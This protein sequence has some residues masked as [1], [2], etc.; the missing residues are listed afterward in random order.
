[1]ET[2]FLVCAILGGT[3]L[4]CQTIAGLVGHGVEH[5]TDADHDHGGDHGNGFL[6]MLTVR[7]VSAAVLFFGH[8]GL[9]SL[10]YGADEPTAFG[11]AFAAGAGALYGV[12]TIMRSLAQL[13]SDGTA[14]IERAIGRP[15]TVYLRVPGGRSGPGKVQLLLQNRTVEYQAVTAGGELST[16]S[17]VKVVAVVNSDTVEVEAV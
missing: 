2:A 9:T 5:D 3:F 7:T 10:Y 11:L 6:G 12:A 13:K 4:A 14:R 16:G 8:G 15:A 1:M 17:Q